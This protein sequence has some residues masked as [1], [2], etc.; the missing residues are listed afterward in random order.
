[1]FS[2]CFLFLPLAGHLC[3]SAYCCQK[4][5]SCIDL[6]GSPPCVS[7]LPPCRHPVRPPSLHA[8]TPP[9]LSGW[10]YNPAEPGRSSDW[11]SAELSFWGN[12]LAKSES[13]VR[14]DRGRKDLRK[15]MWRSW[16]RIQIM[17]KTRSRC[18]NLKGWLI[19]TNDTTF[20]RSGTKVSYRTAQTGNSVRQPLWRSTAN[21]SQVAMPE[22]FATTYLGIN[23]QIRLFVFWDCPL[24]FGI[25]STLCT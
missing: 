24:I 5:E 14:V 16:R 3:G 2:C 8:D 19:P 20:S 10:P 1:M 18:S 22:T 17:T 12:Q 13:W 23:K 15:M 6:A 9:L 4:G 21:V 11:L 25:Y 7:P